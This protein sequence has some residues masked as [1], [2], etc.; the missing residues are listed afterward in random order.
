VADESQRVVASDQRVGPDP[1]GPWH[2]TPE[3]DV[4]IAF[5]TLPA[6]HDVFGSARL[7]FQA[8]VFPVT[9]VEER[10]RVHRS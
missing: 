4:L 3:A 9:W 7:D 2:A 6:M 8:L 5:V 1:E 10:W